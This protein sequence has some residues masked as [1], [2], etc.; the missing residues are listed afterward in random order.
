MDKSQVTIKIMQAFEI[1][2]VKD[3]LKYYGLNVYEV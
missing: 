3:D 1:W 2:F